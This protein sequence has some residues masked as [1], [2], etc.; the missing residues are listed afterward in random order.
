ML[1]VLALELPS[2]VLHEP[3]VVLEEDTQF[4]Q[5]EKNNV[6]RRHREKS[7]DCEL[8]GSDVNEN[9]WSII[10][11]NGIIDKELEKHHVVSGSTTLRVKGAGIERTTGELLIPRQ[12]RHEYGTAPSSVRRRGSLRRHLNDGSRLVLVVHV[13]GLDANTTSEM[14]EM[15]DKVF[16]TFGDKVNLKER[17]EACSY[18]QIRME[19]F[20]SSET[21]GH[22]GVLEV[23]IPEYII[24][25]DRKAVANAAVKA[26]SNLIGDLPSQLDHVMFCLPGGTSGDWIAYAFKNHWIS[27]YNDEW[28]NV[29]SAQM[30]EIGT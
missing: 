7:Y 14:P 19:P 28:C 24:G 13:N 9:E 25:N 16:G 6:F 17:F 4:Q 18:G 26:T 10:S 8:Q 20:S 15:S 21:D 11:I 1:I 30:H 2:K 12:S 5:Y 27:V 23:N 3:C 22:A 29:P